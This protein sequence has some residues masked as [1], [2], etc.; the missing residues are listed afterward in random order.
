[1]Q[2]LLFSGNIK[3]EGKGL[4]IN[5]Y[6]LSGKPRPQ[7]NNIETYHW[8]LQVKGTKK[9]SHLE[10]L[11]VD[12]S[13]F[14][15]DGYIDSRDYEIIDYIPRRE[16]EDKATLE[17]TVPQFIKV[18]IPIKQ[19]KIV[20]EKMP[21]KIEWTFKDINLSNSDTLSRAFEGIV[22]VRFYRESIMKNIGIAISVFPEF[23]EKQLY[24]R[25][26]PCTIPLRIDHEEVKNMCNCIIPGDLASGF[27][28]LEKPETKKMFIY[29]FLINEGILIKGSGKDEIRNVSLRA[30]TLSIL[31]D[32]LKSELG[33]QDYYKIIKSAGRQI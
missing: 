29:D 11:R 19:E 31:F 12:F 4:E 26:I 13:F 22:S 1:M 24:F 32:N 27:A 33:Y 5:L 23:Y 30:R 16:T 28:D 9:Y 20:S 14:G 2:N 6:Q 17:L 15:K 8:A 7:I 21:T 3:K 18:S 25:K 10:E